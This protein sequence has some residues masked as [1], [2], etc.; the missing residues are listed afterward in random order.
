[1]WPCG[2]VGGA[3][4]ANKVTWDEASATLRMKKL[5]PDKGTWTFHRTHEKDKTSLVMMITRREHSDGRHSP[6]ITQKYEQSYHSK[7]VDSQSQIATKKKYRVTKL[8]W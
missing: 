4:R 7:A 5:Y 6:M 3:P 2:P 8:R 1:M